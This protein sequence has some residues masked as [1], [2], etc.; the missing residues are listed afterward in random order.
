VEVQGDPE[1]CKNVD[2][3]VDKLVKEIEDEVV[4]S[5]TKARDVVRM[6]DVAEASIPATLSDV[7]SQSQLEKGVDMAQSQS[8][9]RA[10]VKRHVGFEVDEISDDGNVLHDEGITIEVNQTN[11]VN[12]SNQEFGKQKMAQK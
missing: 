1:A 5:D 3:L 4:H 9:F 12:N 6:D 2:T 11:N 10:A 7:G 8:S